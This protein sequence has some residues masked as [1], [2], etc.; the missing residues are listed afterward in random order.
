MQKKQQQSV[1][2]SQ[3]IMATILTSIP[4]GANVT[5]IDYE[6]PRIALY[7]KTPRF[8][9]ENNTIISN[10]VKQ[11][12][13]RIVIRI[14]ESIRK[15]EDDVRKVLNQKVPKDANLQGIYFDTT[16]GEVSIEVKRPWFCQRNAEEFSHAEIYE[17]TGWK[18]RVRKSTNNP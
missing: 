2:N 18:L 4:K 12:K 17:E 3:N 10:L 7:T 13:K 15:N 16:T 8:L 6:G 9:M 5:K 14:D 1:P 11:I